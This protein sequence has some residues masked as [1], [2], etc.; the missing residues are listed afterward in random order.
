MTIA[1]TLW[2]KHGNLV[3]IKDDSEFSGSSTCHLSLIDQS[4][5][6]D[7]L[8]PESQVMRRSAPEGVSALCVGGGEGKLNAP[9]EPF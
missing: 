7:T 9:Q 1:Q 4:S 8:K 3:K 6:R 2:N 5:S